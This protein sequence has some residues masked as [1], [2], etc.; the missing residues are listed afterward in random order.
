MSLICACLLVRLAAAEDVT[1]N[2]DDESN[3]EG[4]ESKTIEFSG[5]GGSLFRGDAFL[6]SPRLRLNA[7]RRDAVL[8]LK[9]QGY[10]SASLRACYG[11][12]PEGDWAKRD[13]P[14]M[15]LDSTLSNGTRSIVYSGIER[16]VTGLEVVAE[17]GNVA[18]DC[19]DS[20]EGP[21]TRIIEQKN[22]TGKRS[23]VE[24]EAQCRAEFWRI[25]LA[26]TSAHVEIKL[27][28][29]IIEMRFDL[30][31]GDFHTYLVPLWRRAR[32]FLSL[33]TTVSLTRL[34]LSFDQHPATTRGDLR[35]F[36]VDDCETLVVS[37]TRWRLVSNDDEYERL[38]PWIVRELQFFEDAACEKE[39]KSQTRE[40]LSSAAE[41]FDPRALYDDQCRPNDDDWRSIPDRDET[42]I[43]VHFESE[44]SVRCVRICQGD[45]KEGGRVRSVN[46]QFYDDDDEEWIDHA[47]LAL[48]DKRVVVVDPCKL[49]FVSTKANSRRARRVAY[50]QSAKSLRA[51]G[52]PTAGSALSYG[53]AFEL[54]WFTVSRPPLIRAVTGC[55]DKFFQQRDDLTA[56]VLGVATTGLSD[57][58]V[59]ENGHLR[60][61]YAPDPEQVSFVYATTIN[62]PRN[63][64][65]R[66]KLYGERLDS[67]IDVTVAGQPCRN[68]TYEDDVGKSLSCDLPPFA[69]DVVSDV[70]VM[71]ADV[72]E[73][74]HS[75]PYLQYMVP[76]DKPDAPT[77]S[78]IA[79]KSIDV[80]WK[81]S[82][83]LWGAVCIT[84][85]V[86]S[87]RSENSTGE[88]TLGNVTTTTVNNLDRDTQ[89]SFAVAAVAEDRWADRSAVDTVDLYGR[90][91]LLHSALRGV[92]GVYSNDTKTLR[93]DVEMTYFNANATINHGPSD[94]RSTVGP[95]GLT[96][97]GEGRYGLSLVGS[98]SIENCNISSSCADEDT[99]VCSSPIHHHTGNLSIVLEYQN[100][101]TSEIQLPP[102][103]PA[104]RL[105]GGAPRQA[106][107]AWYGRRL[108]VREGFDTTFVLRAA[109][110]SVR[111]NLMNDAYTW[112]RSRGADG[113]AFVVQE[114]RIDALGAAGAGLG[115]D[116]INNSLAVEFDTYYNPGEPYENHV[117][118]HS[119]GFRSANSALQ[120]ASFASTTLIPDLT[121]STIPVRIAY[122]P[123][124][125][126]T[127]LSTTAFQASPHTAR[128]FTNGNFASG[129]FG[130]FGIGVGTL[131][132]Y[133]VDLNTPVIVTPI[134]FDALLKLH[135]GRAYVGFTAATGAETWQVHDILEW[136]FTSLRRDP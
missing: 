27:F 94:P 102:C 75:V 82:G 130:D 72:P 2:F 59:F 119:L 19:G 26:S 127:Q 45:G 85:Y 103:G 68:V 58:F 28:P 136:R 14:E 34:R 110:P 42:W 108:N 122:N 98:A 70:V 49:S 11:R 116:G 20:R 95:T 21:W 99:L 128:F 32:S 18:L 23:Y 74:Y 123:V 54:D 29:V 135:Q 61:S 77:V 36:D 120:Q 121:A 43:G 109:N 51:G 48:A 30:L 87:W 60:R 91:L 13:L 37:S 53:D 31:A 69:G 114:H 47:T 24:V 83:G 89:Y 56:Q 132:V 129:G 8:R 1:W 65:I 15:I 44:V 3:N 111:C 107:A 134:N 112:C 63:G 52:F 46:V 33:D 25:L 86:L 4:W 92:T 117:S 73:L 66:I 104:L 62:C 5:A 12:A 84:G 9:Y 93:Y 76:P 88:I 6:E 133:V 126:S 17:E 124:F 113:F 55:V 67:P 96:G 90:R 40:I 101:T 7:A 100:T 131:S 125:D 39:L 71:R 81:P 22:F 35:D 41:V 79:A 106:G 97:G 10:R 16:I 57:S 50:D 64:G 115:Y 118:V 78:N 38:T 80:H 105:T